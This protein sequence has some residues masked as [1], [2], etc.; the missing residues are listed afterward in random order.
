M[1]KLS[2]FIGIITLIVALLVVGC[3]KDKSQLACNPNTDPC[4]GSCDND[5]DITALTFGYDPSFYGVHHVAPFYNPLNNDQFLFGTADYDLISGSLNIYNISS[6]T[7]TELWN[8]GTFSGGLVGQ[9]NWTR[10]DWI[11][12]GGSDLNIYKV[13]PDG[14]NLTQLTSTGGNRWPECDY[15]GNLIVFNNLSTIGSILMDINGTYI[16]T[17]FIEGDGTNSGW[18]ESSWNSENEI[19][20]ANGSSPLYGIGYWDYDDSTQTSLLVQPSGGQDEMREVQ[21]HPNNQDIYYSKWSNGIFKVNVTDKVEELVK[22]GCYRH[23]YPNI[24]ISNDG[25][26]MLACKLVVDSITPAEELAISEYIVTM[27]INGCNETIIPIP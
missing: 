8:S 14:S 19:A 7:V 9:P 11:V 21:W 27:D 1:N 24:S 22:V 23:Y 17:L 2:S 26:Q 12:W 20:M 16:D 5:I 6:G 25:Q 15:D 10:T 18:K 13:R 3:R 4:P